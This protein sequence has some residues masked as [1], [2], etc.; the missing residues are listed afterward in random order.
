[1]NMYFSIKWEKK[2]WNDL[3]VMYMYEQKFILIIKVLSAS[4]FIFLTKRKLEKKTIVHSNYKQCINTFCFMKET[5]YV[6]IYIFA[7]KYTAKFIVWHF[8]SA[9]F[10]IKVKFIILMY[11]RKSSNHLGGLVV[12][13]FN[14]I[15][16]VIPAI[17]H[18]AIFYT[19]YY[20]SN[21]NKCIKRFYLFV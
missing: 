7:N 3:K 2:Q 15:C 12:T 20:F 4:W 19:Y 13:Y 6:Y 14:L 17:L 16:N 1:M 5:M 11:S 9:R 8:S 10:A 21:N 18:S